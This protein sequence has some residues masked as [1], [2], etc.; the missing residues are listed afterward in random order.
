MKP[1][2]L[3]PVS[4]E[5]ESLGV[6]G[7]P[8]NTTKENRGCRGGAEL[9]GRGGGREGAQAG[10]GEG[11]G[12]IKQQNCTF[13]LKFVEKNIVLFYKTFQT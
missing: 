9:P 7:I 3:S 1:L 6:P 10:V 5:A 2:P 8:Q 12:E 11:G 13:F 4:H